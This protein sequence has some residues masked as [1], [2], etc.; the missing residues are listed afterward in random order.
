MTVRLSR[1]LRLLL[2][3]GALGAA[4]AFPSAPGLAQDGG[5]TPNPSPLIYV[6]DDKPKAEMENAEAAARAGLWGKAIGH[7]L[8]AR[9]KFPQAV[10]R[11]ENGPTWIS[12][13]EYVDRRIAG[14]PPEGLEAYRSVAEPEALSGF[15]KT[16]TRGDL[17]GF[18]RIARDHS[19]TS[20]GD[21][22][23]WICARAAAAAGDFAAAAE[24]TSRLLRGPS[25]LPRPL[26]IAHL[27][28]WGAAAGEPDRCAEANDLAAH[29][30]STGNPP[31]TDLTARCL[32]AAAERRPTRLPP[33]EWPTAGGDPTR[34]SRVAEHPAGE[35]KAWGWPPGAVRPAGTPAPQTR[36]TDESIAIEVLPIVTA[37]R[38][39][40]P[41]PMPERLDPPE[42]R[43]AIAL[44]LKGGEERW[45]MSDT[46][47][48]GFRGSGRGAFGSFLFGGSADR[49]RV[50]LNLLAPVGVDVAGLA[51]GGRCV[52][53]DLETGD[54]R[55]DTQN[56]SESIFHE[57]GVFSPPLVAGGNVC[58]AAL[59]VHAEPE[60]HVIALD[61]TTGA[62][63]WSAF[64]CSGTRTQGAM[65]ACTP[66]LSE[67]NGRLY[68]CT[69]VGAIAALEARTGTILWITSYRGS[70]A[71]AA[72]GQPPI[73]S[74]R[75]RPAMPVPNF[76]LVRGGD[77]YFL[78]TDRSGVFIAR[79][80][81]GSL[82]GVPETGSA[83]YLAGLTERWLVVSDGAESFSA[84]DREGLV[85]SA[86]SRL[87]SNSIAGTLIAGRPVLTDEV[88]YFPTNKALERHEKFRDDTPDGKALGGRQSDLEPGPC[89]DPGDLPSNCTVAD[90]W[91]LVTSGQRLVA[92]FE[93]ATFDEL[94]AHGKGLGF[95]LDHARVMEQNSR[96]ADAMADYRK[97][98]GLL[99]SM[100][101]PV[102][103]EQEIGIRARS[104][105]SVLH[106]R[107]GDEA[108]KLERWED[109]IANYESGLK[110]S[111]SVEDAAPLRFALAAALM[112]SVP[113]RETEAANEY[114]RLMLDGARGL[115]DAGDG[116]RTGVYGLALARLAALRD[117]DRAAFDAARATAATVASVE[118]L[119]P[120]PHPLSLQ[121]AFLATYPFSKE[122]LSVLGDALPT[123]QPGV[124]FLRMHLPVLP[125]PRAIDITYSRLI[126]HALD[127]RPALAWSLIDEAVNRVKSAR[128][129]DE[130]DRT[131][132]I[133][134]LALY[135]RRPA[136]HPF[137]L[138]PAPDGA[139]P[140]RP[141]HEVSALA[142]LP[143]D[144]AL[145]KTDEE[146]KN[147]A[148]PWLCTPET[149]SV[150]T[151]EGFGV[152]RGGEFQWCV[153][154]D[155]PA[156]WTL[157]DS[158]TWIGI[159]QSHSFAPPG[160]L[161][162]KVY[163]GQP[164]EVAGVKTR[165]VLVAANDSPID[166][167]SSL[168]AFL[169]TCQGNT[170]VRLT[171]ARGGKQVVCPATL[172]PRPPLFGTPVSDVAVLDDG[173]LVASRPFQLTALEPDGAVRWRFPATLVTLPEMQCVG[174]SAGRVFVL[175]RPVSEGTDF[176]DPGR[177][178]TQERLVALNAATGAVEWQR[179]IPPASP[180]V[181]LPVAGLGGILFGTPRRLEWFDGPTGL[182]LWKAETMV[183][184]Q[185]SQSFPVLLDGTLCVYA[186]ATGV[187]HG[188]DLTTLRDRWHL[189]VER[190]AYAPAHVRIGSG[191]VVWVSKEGLATS[192]DA[193]T[194]QSRATAV[195]L[196]APAEQPA[197]GD[198]LILGPA[199]VACVSTTKATAEAEPIPHLAAF[200]WPD[201]TPR[202]RWEVTFPAHRR[203]QLIDGYPA[204]VLGVEIEDS[205]GL[206]VPPAGATPPEANIF[207]LEPLKGERVWEVRVP[208]SVAGRMPQV[209]A[210][211]GRVLVAGA[212]GVHVFEPEK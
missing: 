198:F 151:P 90:R 115:V 208:V 31:L 188:L 193:V 192:V 91:I 3:A 171:V 37:G 212:D 152:C 117:R 124:D 201:G 76:P 11:L 197:L 149:P 187:W 130:K 17:E 196:V 131:A 21:D 170:P 167:L 180:R 78:P 94:F 202:R 51:M 103:A 6:A 73:R 153:G 199:A 50:Y 92:L 14:L 71:A 143:D 100:P 172:V 207:L 120:I 211:P 189:P 93:Q 123:Q 105:L 125:D 183:G 18:A 157:P 159:R 109:A 44:D 138:R 101:A 127:E 85:T 162:E 181:F 174:A 8:T 58:F 64:V 97:I 42:S 60:V 22:S 28:L 194:G 49:G 96:F 150:I 95:W 36:R 45:G 47:P 86:H 84:I 144:L 155:A 203:I 190:T 111:T 204:G 15:A 20:V 70:S 56:R 57:A 34:T 137:R 206:P 87:H 88:W 39:I 24:W 29:E 32:A 74:S 61:A 200:E 75:P 126:E 210:Q 54:V 177:N 129:G 52:A 154:A 182:S 168:I 38:V 12:L 72:G 140:C 41:I 186:E 83:R 142:P 136:V 139:T 43:S 158:R 25:S 185:D 67:S 118:I 98:L 191:M 35:M 5:E 161:I 128:D 141:L 2:A 164:A 121:R 59:F 13:R 122:A 65:V 175:V 81:D 53:L 55:W 112:R 62:L 146:I 68:C 33:G 30:P 147:S 19:L 89:C 99:S 40:L 23:A 145:A 4:V 66:T 114:S 156:K 107:L 179:V 178:V 135:R 80:S 110:T 119:A 104:A 27:A 108:V 195:S 1:S 69:N 184:M 133:E 166:S 160:V 48:V 169:S 113:P 79:T 163:A 173:G 106:R 16:R 165:D 205:E 176:L 102:A 209:V 10:W 132:A 63:R 116:V 7:W 26:L 46:N 9:D 148:A 77:C 82:K 134:H